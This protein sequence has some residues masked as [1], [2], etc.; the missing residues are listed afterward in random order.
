MAKKIIL[1]ACVSK[2]GNLNT[3]AKELYIS[4]LFKSSLMYANKQNPNKI[5]ILSALHHLLDID[6]EIEP[7]N[8]TLSIVPKAKR[9]T[10][11]KILTSS[12][13]KSGVKRL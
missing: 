4:P 3:K 1:I 13:K 12:E 2:K 9:K 6:K 10:G 7:Y 8:M 5:Y 11:L